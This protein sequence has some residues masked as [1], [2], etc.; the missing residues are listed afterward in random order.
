LEFLLSLTNHSSRIQSISFKIQ[1]MKNL[2]FIAA[3]LFSLVPS[4][5][6]GKNIRGDSSSS[7][8]PF[9]RIFSSSCRANPS[10]A[11]LNLKG[12]CCPT[13]SGHNHDCCGPSKCEENAG[14]NA[15]GLQG[16]CCPVANG[17]FLDC[18]APR[19]FEC[20]QVPAC[21]ALGLTGMCCPAPG[22][23]MLDCCFAGTRSS[24]V[25]DYTEDTSPSERL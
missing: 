18:C 12:Q 22:G 13:D 5:S 17:K 3:A 1:D 21:D 24:E 25:E 11:A 2:G 10:C 6:A 14:C 19:E 7:P 8:F 9:E 4:V 23:L 20:S 16:A 15:L